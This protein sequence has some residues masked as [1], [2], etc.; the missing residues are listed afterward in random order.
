M[1]RFKTKVEADGDRQQLLITRDFDLPVG[2]LYRAYTEADLVAQ[3]ME[4]RVLKLDNHPHG[5]YIF[6]K[7]DP[8]GNVLFRANGT[9]H[10]VEQD[11]RIIRTFEMENSPFEVQLEFLD[12]EALDNDRSR[13]RIQM[14][15]RSVADRDMLLSLPFQLGL[16]QAH[17][18][19]EQ[20]HYT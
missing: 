18:R 8:A 4:N 3:W 15:F 20:L 13:L 11:K 17:E 16:D 7:T 12:F 10:L 1:R 14:V 2:L 5:G 9:I 6:E 19:L